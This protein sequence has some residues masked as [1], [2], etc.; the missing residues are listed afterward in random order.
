MTS[1]D[2]MMVSTTTAPTLTTADPFSGP[3]GKH[4][5]GFFQLQREISDYQ[6]RLTHR[7]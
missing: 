3:E 4:L 5:E 1:S 2:P 6:T 7:V